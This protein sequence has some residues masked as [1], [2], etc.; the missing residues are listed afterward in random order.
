MNHEWS[1]LTWLQRPRELLEATFYLRPSFELPEQFSFRCCNDP[2]VAPGEPLT[3]EIPAPCDLVDSGETGY[4]DPLIGLVVE[5][6]NQVDW[7]IDTYDSVRD[8]S[9]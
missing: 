9:L 6:E 1:D 5:K 4:L 7:I 8:E 2:Q 3:R